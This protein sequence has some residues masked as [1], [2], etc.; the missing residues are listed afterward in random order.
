M[1]MAEHHSPVEVVHGTVL[2]RADTLVRHGGII[3]DPET[4]LWD[5]S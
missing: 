2:V 5:E 1:V 3:I 4:A